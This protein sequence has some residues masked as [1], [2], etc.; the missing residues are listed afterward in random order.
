MKARAEK[1]GGRKR[2]R[3]R[4]DGGSETEIGEG[5]AAERV[6]VALSQFQVD[7]YRHSIPVCSSDREKQS[8]GSFVRIKRSPVRQW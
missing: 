7:F 6:A 4:P 3:G 2:A 8:G 1:T 5:G